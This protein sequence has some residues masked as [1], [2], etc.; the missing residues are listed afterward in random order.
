MLRGVWTD[1][2]GAG[3]EKLAKVVAAEQ[4]ERTVVLGDMNGTTDD[5]KLACLTPAAALGPGPS[6]GRPR[7]QLAGVLPEGADR[8]D[9]SQGRGAEELV[10]PAGD[11]QRSSAGGGSHQLVNTA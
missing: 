7:L 1:S 9:P 4:N 10:G 2:R 3:A 11:R 5:R 6:R 8:S